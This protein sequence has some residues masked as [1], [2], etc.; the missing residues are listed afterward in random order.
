MKVAVVSGSPRRTA[1][2]Q[3]MMR[4]VYEYAKSKNPDTVFINLSE[5]GVECYRGPD[6]QY[7]QATRDAAAALTAADVW[8]VGSPVYNSFFSSALKNLFEYV[9]YKD[10]AGKVAGMAIMASGGIGFINVQNLITQ[11]LSYFRI[12]ANPRAVFL[13]TEAVSGGTV[14][15]ADAAGRLRAMVDETLAMASAL[16]PQG[17]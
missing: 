9:N 14:S 7:G 3:V 10:T 15:D 12:V 6:E 16:R 11:M 2:T 4:H 17:A 5:G 1:N 8:L 13:T